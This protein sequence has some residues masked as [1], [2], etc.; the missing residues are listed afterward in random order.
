MMS[1]SALFRR[2]VI[3]IRNEPLKPAAQSEF[4]NI[5]PNPFVGQRKNGGEHFSSFNIPAEGSARLNPSGESKERR[6]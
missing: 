5:F 3:W 2:D 1:C 6:R 4:Q